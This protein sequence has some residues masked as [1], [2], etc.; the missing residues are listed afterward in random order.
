MLRLR[1]TLL[2]AT[3]IALAASGVAYAQ[4]SSNFDPAQLPTV[5]G[6]VAQYLPTPRG[7]VDGLLLEDGTEV[8]FPP[9]L[10]AELVFAVKPG[11]S[12]TIHG[13]KARAEPM[14]DAASIT[15]DAT[16]VTVVDTGPWHHSE[17]SDVH[18]QGRIKAEL[19]TSRGDLSGVVLDDGTVVHLPPPEAARLAD[20]LAVGKMLVAYGD[21]FSGPLGRAI[22]ARQI[23]PD[24]AHMVAVGGPRPGWERWMHEHFGHGPGGGP[25]MGEDAPPPPP[26]GAPPPP[27]AQ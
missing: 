17:A 25:G 5:T 9:H 27:P 14:V 21:G 12:V 1:D 15:N 6:K 18:V 8:H 13:L 22:G 2:T 16:K 20:Q 11:D 23:G 3:L 10:S 4:M 7:D 19:H 24:S 26:P